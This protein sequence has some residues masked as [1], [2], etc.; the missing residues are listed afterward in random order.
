MKKIISIILLLPLLLMLH[1]QQSSA[2][3]KVERMDGADRFEVAV[4]ISKEGWPNAPI[5]TVVLANYNAYA[6]ALSAAPLA[7]SKNAPILLTQPSQLTVA[8]KQEISRLSPKEVIIIGGE[9]SVSNNVAAELTSLGVSN[10]QRISGLNRFEVSAAI[11]SQLP[12]SAQVVIADG[13]NFPDALAIAPYAAKNGFPILLTRPSSLPAEIKTVL[14]ARSPQKSIVVGGTASVSAQVASQLPDHSRIGGSNRY[15]VAANIVRTYHPNVSKAFLATG[16]SFADALTG[17][18]LAA[19]QNAPLLL[20]HSSYLPEQ[21]Q[22]IIKEKAITDFIVLGGTASVSQKAVDQ[23]QVGLVGLKIVVDA[24]HGG[25]DPGATGNG[26]VEKNVTLDVA[27]RLQSKLAAQGASV[28]MTRSGDTYPSLDERADLANRIGADVFVSI[29]INAFSDPSVNGTE[30]F[31]NSQYASADSKEL[32][33]LIQ[34]E[35]V[36]ELGT[37][38]RG[39]KQANFVVIKN[40]KMASALAEL[41]FVSNS[42]DA[43]LL[44]SSTYRDKAA[45]GIYQGISTYWSNK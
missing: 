14:S 5:N 7:Y 18:V 17:S 35:M 19:K 39:V 23:T 26:L 20:T 45:Q 44:E 41:A 15:E 9:G 24:G 22:E 12:A 21:T 1:V 37:N 28:T 4:N 33:T 13:T 34:K 8:T 32:A 25:T 40:T 29:H 11:A 38:N 10:V 6:D 43:A 3:E 2:A 16:L 27:K 30:T 31:W 42:K 36:A